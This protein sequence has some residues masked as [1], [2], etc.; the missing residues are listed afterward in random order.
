MPETLGVNFFAAG[1]IYAV[2]ASI[3]DYSIYPT[4][5]PRLFYLSDVFDS[6]DIVNYK[7]RRHLPSRFLLNCIN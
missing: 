5:Y 7:M 1:I 2:G 6:L 4:F 3:R